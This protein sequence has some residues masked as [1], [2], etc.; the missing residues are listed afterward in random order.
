MKFVRVADTRIHGLTLHLV[1]ENRRLKKKILIIVL[2][3][4]R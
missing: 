2:T 1:F 3:V 4:G